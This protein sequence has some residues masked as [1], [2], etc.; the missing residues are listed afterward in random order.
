MRNSILVLSLVAGLSA[1]A[2]SHDKPAEGPME[3]AGASVDEAA[4][5][6]KKGVEKATEKTGEAVGNAGDKVKETTKDEN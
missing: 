5:D 1:L 6:T 2:C 3:K 4:H